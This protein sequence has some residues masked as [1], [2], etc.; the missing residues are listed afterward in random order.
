MLRVPR[1]CLHWG[2][3]GRT[4]RTG[5]V[6]VLVAEIH[7]SRAVWV[8]RWSWGK[9]R[10]LLQLSGCRDLRSLPQWGAHRAH[11][12]PA[13]EMPHPVCDLPSPPAPR[14]SVP[15]IGERLRNS[16][17]PGG[18]GVFGTNHNVCAVQAREP[19]PHPSAVG[20]THLDPRGPP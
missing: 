17:P 13:T 7:G 15:E 5:C 18:E 10:G 14:D 12:A 16:R 1:L 11:P 2:F 4:G 3:A 6:A 8:P 20:Q 9:P 19:P